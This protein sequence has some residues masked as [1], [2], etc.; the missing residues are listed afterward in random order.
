MRRSKTTKITQSNSLNSAKTVK[1][2]L[3]KK[4]TCLDLLPE[5]TETSDFLEAGPQKRQIKLT[6]KGKAYAA[7]SKQIKKIRQSLDDNTSLET[8]ESER[9]YLDKLKDALNEAQK[10]IDEMIDNEK[11][12]QDSYHWFD[13]RDRECFE[14]RAKL[15]ERINDLE[16]TK[17]KSPSGS[18]K[19][20][21]SRRTKSS[22][23]S[24]SSHSIRLGDAA[25]TARLRAEMTFFERDSEMQRLQLMK[26]IAIAEAE[27]QAIR[28][29]LKEER[30]DKV[31]QETTIK[32]EPNVPSFVPKLPLYEPQDTQVKESLDKKPAVAVQI[33]ENAATFRELLSLQEKHTELSSMLVKQNQLNHLPV[34]EPPVFSGDPFD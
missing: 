24:S 34:K 8:L 4:K 10:A 18:V 2:E 23:S 14:I 19:S 27:E 17:F 12:K 5:T 26:D 1:K 11:D 25:S 32:L 7:L 28:E 33:D 15:V 3:K 6:E 9:D 21:H 31:K 22:L 29:G 16:Q 20:G 13:I 30:Q